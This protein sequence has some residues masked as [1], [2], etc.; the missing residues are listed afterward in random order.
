MKKLLGIVLLGLLWCNV[1]FAEDYDSKAGGIREPGT[2]KKCFYVFEREN[3]FERKFLPKVKKNR[4]VFVTY[5]GCNKY[6][7]DWSWEYSLNPDID[8]A[9]L[10]AYGLC[11]GNELP[12][13]NLTGCHLFSINDVIVWGKDAAFVT[14]V[15]KEAQ[16]GL[17]TK[18]AK[19]QSENAEELNKNCIKMGTTKFNERIKPAA[20][21][22]EKKNQA[23]VMYF[24]CID[25]NNWYWQTGI[26]DDLDKAKEIA[27][28]KCVSKGAQWINNCH[29][30]SI[31]DKIVYGDPA[32]KTKVE[33]KLRKKLAKIN[34]SKKKSGAGSYVHKFLLWDNLI[35]SKKSPT[36][37]KKLTFN[38][39]KN[40]G[41][42]IKRVKRNSDWSKKKT[43]RSF[44]FE[45]EFEDNI[46]VEIF[47]E[48]EKDKKDFKKAEKEALFFSHMYGQMPHFLKDYNKKIYVHNDN[49]YDDGLGLWWVSYQKREFHINAPRVNLKPSGD[50]RC[51]ED[52]DRYSH[53]TV[54]MV[55][56]LAHIIQQLTG[57]ISPSKWSKA[58]KL[59][60]KK[61]A[62]EYSKQNSK[63]DFAES[64]TAWI[65]VRHKSDR[66]SESDLKKFNEFIPNR[67]KL[68]DEMNFNMH[69]ISN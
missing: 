25:M 36:T 7:D 13:Y 65:A 4:G 38:K 22:R 37:F 9:H 44:S 1:G 40:I 61:Y 58:R 45:A 56:E 32:L 64:L 53:C 12:K 10:K 48:Y 21:T 55:H 52:T 34:K 15:E 35:F 47:V 43:F 17:T 19:K 62:S 67:L 23:Y 69:P 59:D 26:E 20:K 14:K 29:L 39:E 54:V 28:S 51:G 8:A 11:A 66:I 46:T 42:I 31:G 6:Y 41:Q 50:Q 63:E 57:V 2:D 30:F 18:I 27:H 24:G 3:I 5:I 68:F 49:E 16:E 33:E 60:K